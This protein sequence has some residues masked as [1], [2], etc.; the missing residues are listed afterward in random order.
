MSFPT[1]YR[2]HY[3]HMRET[4]LYQLTMEMWSTVTVFVLEYDTPRQYWKN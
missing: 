1:T 4:I 3:A 2:I